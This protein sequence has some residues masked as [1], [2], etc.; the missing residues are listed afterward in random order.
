M[1]P[2]EGQTRAETWLKAARHLQGCTYWEDYNVIL[3]VREPGARGPADAAIEAAVNALLLGAGALPVNSVAETIFPA[4]EY[5]LHRERGVYEIYPDEVFPKIRSLLGWGTYAHRLLR[6]KGRDNKPMN[7]LRVC[8][9]K[10][11]AQLAKAKGLKRACYELSTVGEDDE[12]Y[13]I[14]LYWPANDQ[15]Q[16]LGLPCLSH[17]SLKITRERRLN[18]TAL[19]RSHY[20]VERALG[21]LLG[22]ARL[23]DFICQQTGL[24]RGVLVCHSTHACLDTAARRAKTRVEELLA[25]LTTAAAA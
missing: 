21:N 23:Q 10:I 3:E 7:P 16:T 14:P 13:E 19:Y 11:K 12:F 4:N 22:L 8:V 5:K 20:Y 1:T 18:L 9:E 24:A 15:K 6:R 25:N 2:I 17:I